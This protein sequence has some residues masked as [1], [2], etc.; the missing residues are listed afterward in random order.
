ME[1]SVSGP[2]EVYAFQLLNDKYDLKFGEEL[3]EV[4][5]MYLSGVNT[6]GLKQSLDSWGTTCSPVCTDVSGTCDVVLVTVSSALLSVQ[7]ISVAP[8]P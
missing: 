4:A 7:S 2:V 8:V 3:M 5:L 6:G 1:T